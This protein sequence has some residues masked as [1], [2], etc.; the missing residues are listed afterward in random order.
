MLK[1]LALTLGWKTN[2]SPITETNFLNSIFTTS[3]SNFSGVPVGQ[4]PDELNYQYYRNLILNSA[5]LFKSKGTRKSIEVLLRF[6]GAP[7]FLVDFNE[8]VY[9]ADQ[10]ISLNDFETQYA[11]ISGGTYTQTTAVLDPTDVYTIMGVQYTGFTTTSTITDISI[12]QDAYPLDQ[13]GC[14]STPVDSESY[15]FQIGGGW[16]ESTPQHRMPEQIDLT[17]SVFTGTNP[18]YQTKL[19]PFNYGEEYLDRYRYFPYMNLGFRL[20]RTQDNKKSWTD[21]QC[22]SKRYLASATS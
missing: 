13:F 5:F 10:R 7:D 14:P 11:K 8:Y 15:Y 6:I 17:T 1:N 22:A 20:R 19:R 9:L 16:F 12:T 18:N 3:D 21:T 4:T 2:I